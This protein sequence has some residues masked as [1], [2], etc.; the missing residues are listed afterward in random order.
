MLEMDSNTFVLFKY[1]FIILFSS[2]QASKMHM[3]CAPS[4]RKRTQ[5][6]SY[7]MDFDLYCGKH[8]TNVK[9]KN[10]FC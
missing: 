7:A 4:D 10:F 1:Q 9:Q 6:Q 3:H 2:Q 8:H 5:A